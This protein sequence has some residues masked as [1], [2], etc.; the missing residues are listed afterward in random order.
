MPTGNWGSGD[1][2]L[3]YD[4]FAAMAST[5]PRWLGSFTKW[6]CFVALT[7]AVALPYYATIFLSMA[8]VFPFKYLTYRLGVFHAAQD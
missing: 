2:E 8:I 7:H 3:P 6:C 4:F 1:W 5:L